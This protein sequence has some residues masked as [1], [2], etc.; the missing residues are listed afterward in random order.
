MHIKTQKKTKL[1]INSFWNN[2]KKN[3]IHN[4]INYNNY[5]NN[6]KKQIMSKMNR[7]L[8]LCIKNQ[9]LALELKS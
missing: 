9:I 3:L 2:K 7:H 4:K 6:S 8:N 5:N 1:S